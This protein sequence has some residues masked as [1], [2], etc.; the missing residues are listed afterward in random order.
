[1]L[2][3]LT[4]LPTLNLIAILVAIFL[5]GY[6]LGIIGGVHARRRALDLYRGYYPLALGLHSFC[7]L[8][9]G[10]TVCII[11]PLLSGNVNLVGLTFIVF[12]ASGCMG[13][14]V[15]TSP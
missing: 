3:F 12:L 13:Y 7:A 5:T 14:M 6:L 2:V 11:V 1:M 9:L 8:L 15:A 10:V 4:T